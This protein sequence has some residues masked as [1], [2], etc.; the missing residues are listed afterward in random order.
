MKLA[1][2]LETCKDTSGFMRWTTRAYHT[3][4]P[5]T[6]CAA[7]SAWMTLVPHEWALPVPGPEDTCNPH[8][9]P[10]QGSSDVFI[11][12]D[13]Q[14]PSWDALIQ[15]KDKDL[16]TACARPKKEVHKMRPD[17]ERR[18][19]CAVVHAAKV[20]RLSRRSG[21]PS[22]VEN[23]PNATCSPYPASAPAPL[24]ESRYK[25]NTPTCVTT[26]SVSPSG[27]FCH[28]RLTETLFPTL[29]H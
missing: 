1:R 7:P 11:A 6:S 18:R 24:A 21:S 10:L 28:P 2:K 23:A 4:P 26:P 9:F 14:S 19:R 12:V 22:S 27:Q 25:N 29:Q 5:P 15:A 16:R 3:K 20:A 17:S 8:N 13:A